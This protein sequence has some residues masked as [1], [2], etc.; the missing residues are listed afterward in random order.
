MAA[1]ERELTGPIV[2]ELMED[3]YRS[4]VHDQASRFDKLFQQLLDAEG[5]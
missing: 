2:V 5:S 3:L 1:A 4:L